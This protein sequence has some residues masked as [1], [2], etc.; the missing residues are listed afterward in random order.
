MMD[1]SGIESVVVVTGWCV[2]VIA[3][4]AVDWWGVGA[5]NGLDE[6]AT[7]LVR[8]VAEDV[9]VKPFGLCTEESKSPRELDGDEDGKN[10][11]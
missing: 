5:V 1:I 6:A 4:A 2:L 7:G 3:A 8:H 10:C 11:T 9:T